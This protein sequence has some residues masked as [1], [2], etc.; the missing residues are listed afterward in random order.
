MEDKLFEKIGGFC[1]YCKGTINIIEGM[2][3]C[4]TLDLNGSPNHLNTEDY[5]VAGYC[6]RCKRSLYVIPNNTGGYTVYP[7]NEAIPSVIHNIYL[8]SN[9]F[10]R[11]SLLGI[12]LL[13]KEDNNPFI[14]IK[15]E[16]DDCPF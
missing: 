5:K 4:Y 10:Q 13:E 11:S 14:N 16:D 7:D 1:P 2:V 8:M 15:P 12:K 6:E 9:K 3:Y